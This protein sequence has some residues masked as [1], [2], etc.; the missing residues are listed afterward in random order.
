MVNKDSYSRCQLVRHKGLVVVCSLA[1]PALR[2]VSS[3]GIVISCT[4]IYHQ[5]WLDLV[6]KIL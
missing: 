3:S 6:E 5:V 4:I 1:L 2:P